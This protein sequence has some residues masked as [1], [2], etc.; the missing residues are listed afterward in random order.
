MGQFNSKGSLKLTYIDFMRSSWRGIRDLVGVVDSDK[1]FKD[2][3]IDI[4][5]H[6]RS[7]NGGS[8]IKLFQGNIKLAEWLAVNTGR[9][10][11]I[12]IEDGNAKAPSLNSVQY[13][14]A[15]SD[16][17]LG[18]YIN[19]EVRACSFLHRVAVYTIQ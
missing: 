16:S 8:S 14:Y 4:L 17:V 6:I 18:K 13:R 10:I 7:I 3:A 15:L 5:N 11:L 2:I 9:F 19:E 1:E 12:Y